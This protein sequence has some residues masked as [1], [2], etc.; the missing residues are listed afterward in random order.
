MV[1]RLTRTSRKTSGLSVEYLKSRTLAEPWL[2]C[3]DA[4]PKA[5]CCPNICPV[6]RCIS[7]H[8]SGG[9]LI[10]ILCDACVCPGHFPKVQVQGAGEISEAVHIYP[11][12]PIASGM[13]QCFRVTIG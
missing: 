5:H 3:S 9:V 13:C 4:K 12:L 1:K 11:Y 6:S 2:D 8:L 10:Q 7:R